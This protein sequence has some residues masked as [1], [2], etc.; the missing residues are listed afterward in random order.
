MRFEPAPAAKSRFIARGP[1]YECVL[2]AAGAKLNAHGKLLE[3]RFERAN[4]AALVQGE[5]LLAS[6]TNLLR[7]NHAADWR[8]RIPN[9]SRLRSTVIYP[10]IDAVYYGN[11]GSL[12]YDFI[13]KAGADP[14][15]IRI[16]FV[17]ADMQLDANGNLAGGDYVQRR[18]ASYQIAANGVKTAVVSAFRRNRD[19][20]F[21]FALGRYDH[22]RELIIDPQLTFSAYF[23]GSFQDAAVAVGHD[24]HG[25]VYVAG[26]TFSTNLPVTDNPYQSASGGDADVFVVKLDPNAAPGAQV[27]YSTFAGGSAA[28]TLK[29]MVVRPDGTVYL[30]GTTLS[31]NF[32]IGNAAQSTLNGTSDAFVL[33]LDPS[34]AGLSAIF[35]GTYLGG[36]GDDA[37]NDIAVDSG[38]K[39]YVA[40]STRSNDFP[41]PGG[42]QVTAASSADAFFA[43]IDTTQSATATLVY[44]TYLGGSAWEEGTAVA[45]ARD[46]TAWLAGVTWSYDFPLIGVSYQNANHVAGDAFLAHINPLAA[47]GS[48]LLYTTY[49]GG[50]DQDAAMRV[51]VD[52]AGR[53]VVT[54]YTLSTDFPVTANAMQPKSGGDAD[55]FIAVVDPAT[56]T[57]GLVSSTYFGGNGGDVPQAMT[58]DSEGNIYIA[59]YTLS[60][61][62]PVTSN[63]LESAPG[64]GVD[65]F[66]VRLNPAR[67]APDLVSYVTSSG[68][69]TAAGIDVDS[70]GVVYVAGYTS[71][72]LLDILGGASKV[73]NSG[74]RDGFVLAYAP[75]LFTVSPNTAQFEAA[76]GSATIAITTG[77]SCAWTASSALDWI[78]VAP[79][80][81]SGNGAVMVTAA[82]N[83]TGA[84]RSGSITIAGAA[85]A[86]TQAQ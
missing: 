58:Q 42:Y 78:S 63:A 39:I 3:V 20:T 74:D 67:S 59:G 84:T 51:T 16:R 33:V 10:G 28:D 25:F 77:A 13:V 29:A 31:S 72:P 49:L 35:Y 80:S 41:A 75:C 12:E 26:T 57:S 38:G 47:G 6:T 15:Q 86:I 27:V 70:N 55:V 53:A 11:G 54:G 73:T 48:S 37:A 43:M 14:E 68:T 65:G 85:V 81:G 24:S 19:G 45:V 30:A 64:G 44:S 52:S 50:S 32:P 22:R 79:G 23:A 62:L 21:G 56:G 83:D 1:R 36:S 82:A 2:D 46:G 71:G 76:G 18:P 40:G 7:G 17:G 69:Q 9:Y 34:Q 8:T 5:G 66:I 60:T 4:S 61:N